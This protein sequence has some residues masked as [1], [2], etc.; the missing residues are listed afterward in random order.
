MIIQESI[1]FNRKEIYMHYPLYF[2][3]FNKMIILLILFNY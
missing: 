2:D 3:S 1:Q